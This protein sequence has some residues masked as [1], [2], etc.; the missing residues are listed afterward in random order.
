MSLQSHVPQEIMKLSNWMI[1]NK[2]TLSKTKSFYMLENKKTLKDS[3][4]SV[5]IKQNLIEKSECVKY[6]AVDILT[7]NYFGKF[8]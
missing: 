8:V 7:T 5:L 6:L 3:N 2:S 1:S 4:F